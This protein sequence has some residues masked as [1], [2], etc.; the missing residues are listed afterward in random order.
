MPTTHRRGR[1]LLRAAVL[2]ICTAVIGQPAPA[3]A[4]D[5]GG[6]TVG[7]W[8]GETATHCL[9]LDPSFCPRDTSVYTPELWSA[10]AETHAALFMNFVY[11][12]DFGPI[13]AGQAQRTD[14]IPLVQEANRRGIQVNAWI[15]F[16]TD[17]GTYSNEANAANSQ[18]AVKDFAA[19]SAL[20]GLR[21]H[22]V[23]LDLEQATGDQPIAEALAGDLGP[24]TQTMHGNVDPAAQCRSLQTYRA[25]ISWA[26]QH[27]IRMTGSPVPFALDDVVLDHNM[28]LSNVLQIAPFAPGMYDDVY[29]QAYRTFGVDFG[30]AYIAR[31]FLLMQQY[32]GAQGQISLGNT[33]L[34]PYDTTGALINDIE[35]LAGMGATS[36]PIFDLNQA[37]SAYG[38]A[39]V[40]AVVNAGH[41]PLT[42]ASLQ[43]A[44]TTST[45][46][47][48]GAVSLFSVL[49]TTANAL[50][51]AETTLTG[52]P[53]Q[54]NAWP[55]GCGAT[56]VA[57]LM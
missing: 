42:G 5:P 49:N 11:E 39:G 7:F 32:F 25:T 27:G 4:V 10:L 9:A 48:A 37:V 6:T 47:G 51:Q 34:P 54:P 50:T 23:T 13:P 21:I 24:I 19:W 38:I 18:A 1:A 28:G 52:I 36:I 20:H 12:A 55:S 35:M 17:L 16:P 41:H 26:H 40:K 33:G 46:A 31:Y 45:P 53:R 30:S 43:T 3:S 44:E 22:E 2:L 15:T 29:L 14:V 8:A 56:T 57:P